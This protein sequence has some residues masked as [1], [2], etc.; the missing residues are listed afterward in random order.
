MAKE[1]IG[2]NATFTG[3]QKGLTI[4]KDHCYAYSGEIISATGGDDIMLDFTTGK[5]YL[6]VVLQFG[7]GGVRS[8]DDE[9]VEIYLNNNL[10]A[11]NIYNN[12]Y[13]RGELNDF[14]CVL[15]PL[16]DV[17]VKVVKGSGTD[18][19]ETFVWLKGRVY[20]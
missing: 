6:M 5:Q 11:S 12:N 9:Q 17:K 10:V 13:E 15:P 3:P 19:V 8:N 14:Q 20:Q 18:N 7:F 1:R 4:I 2:S 16:T